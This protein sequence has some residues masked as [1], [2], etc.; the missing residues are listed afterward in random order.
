MKGLL[1]RLNK[2]LGGKMFLLFLFTF[3][4]V[5]TTVLGNIGDSSYSGIQVENYFS[6]SGKQGINQ[7]ISFNDSEYNNHKL[8]FEDGLLVNYTLLNLP[9]PLEM[10]AHFSEGLVAYYNLDESSGTIAYDGIGNS[11]G[12]IGNS[13]TKNV[14]GIINKAETTPQNSGESASIT[15]IPLNLWA[16]YPNFSVSIWIKGNATG[17][18]FFNNNLAG[19]D[20][21]YVINDVG[22][23]DGNWHHVVGT[24]N[25]DLIEL[26]VDGI[27]KGTDNT[28][29]GNSYALTYYPAT[30]L[31]SALKQDSGG[32]NIQLGAYGSITLD[33]VGIWN[34]ILNST[35]VAMLYN[36]GVG[37]TYSA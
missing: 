31:I 1:K 37:L 15:A 7:N 8:F 5:I 2:V 13:V 12:V 30:E 36:N 20:R 23:K 19:A 34:R 14:Q 11:N 6:G 35:E 27:S 18:V 33:E 26:Y 4:F 17:Y 16:N 25:G 3:I 9:N 24:R 10:P 29:G 32:G 21:G 22:T 28:S